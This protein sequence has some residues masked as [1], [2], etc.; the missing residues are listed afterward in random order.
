MYAVNVQTPEQMKDYGLPAML[1]VAGKQ[2]SDQLPE[3]RESARKL[4][5]RLHSAHRELEVTGLLPQDT[6][7][8]ELAATKAP[9]ATDRAAVKARVLQERANGN[10]AASFGNAGA[11]G[12]VKGA[13]KEAVKEMA[14]P[15]PEQSEWERFLA[16]NLPALQCTAVLG[17]TR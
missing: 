2:I 1:K 10:S 12:P 16:S 11:A 3:A 8:A 15:A 13:A 5:Q 17:L 7:T 9:V 6:S 4:A 14:E